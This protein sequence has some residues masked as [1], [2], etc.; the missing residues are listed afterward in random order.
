[1]ELGFFDQVDDVVRSLVDSDLGELRTRFHR[2]GIIVW[3]N[4]EKPTRSHFE[5]QMVGRHHVDGVTGLALEIG[6]HAEER[7]ESSNQQILDDLSLV[8]GE[9]RPVLGSQAEAGQ[10]LGSTTWRRISDVWIEPD[11]DDSDSP[12]EVGARLVDY[13]QALQPH[14]SGRRSDS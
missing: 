4:T 13:L 12:F 7:D 2:R 9:W 11:L 14:L 6:F 3:F 5:A 10:F 8:E 1:M